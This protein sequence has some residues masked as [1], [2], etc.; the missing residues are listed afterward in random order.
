MI[1][2]L[3]VMN[4]SQGGA[5][6]KSNGQGFENLFKL[7][8]M[9]RGWAVVKINDGCRRVSAHKLI[10]VKQPFDFVLAKGGHVLC[11]D[12]KTQDDTHFSRT[13]I[14]EHQIK[15]LLALEKQ[16]VISGYLVYLRKISQVVFFKASVLNA[17][18]DGD[19]GI[20][21][22]DGICLGDLHQMDLGLMTLDE[23]K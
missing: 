13:L 4:R 14:K 17:L 16:G 18:K 12:T 6:A 19:R 21:P 7:M 2:D 9:N 5:K 23:R 10:P 1:C 8:A 20:Y 22:Q 15:E 11:L 3:K